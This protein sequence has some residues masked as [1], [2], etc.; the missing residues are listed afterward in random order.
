MD[1]KA[2]EEIGLSK[3]E[4]EVYVALLELGQSHARVIVTK[5]NIPQSKIYEVLERL[6]Q[7]GLVNYIIVENRRQYSASDP[8]ILMDYLK[9]KEEKLNL[10][11]PTLN[12]LQN[13]T[14]ENQKVELY[15]GRTAVFKLLRR[16]VD[17]SNEGEEYLSF[18]F[19][20]EHADPNV[21]LFYLN[22]HARRLEKKLNVKV[23]MNRDY[24][25]LHKGIYSKKIMTEIKGKYTNFKY[26]Q[27][28]TVF[29]NCVVILSWEP[30]ATA[31]VI[32]SK[33]L[34]AQYKD[35]FYD[36]YNNTKS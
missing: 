32:H 5:S 4:K 16:M 28:F 22:L 6:I 24:E 23:L 7:K 1:F 19:G 36:V 11:L 2:L 12:K 3:R 9:D 29:R 14:K 21:S 8:D 17:D 33:N 18:S 27:G 35:F 34:Y 10:I 13:K 20:G 25:K 30:D 15:E 26:P 31:V